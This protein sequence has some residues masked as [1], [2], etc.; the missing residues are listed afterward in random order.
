MWVVLVLISDA[1]G[2]PVANDLVGPK[3]GRAI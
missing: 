1:K 3:T 2:V